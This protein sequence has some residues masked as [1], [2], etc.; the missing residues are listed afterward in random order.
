MPASEIGLLRLGRT[1]S[2]DDPELRAKLGEIQKG[3][4]QSTGYPFYFLQQRDDPR[5]IYLLGEWKSLDQHYNGL[6]GSPEFR[7]LARIQGAR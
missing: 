3:L 5:L 1:K 7:E 2:V 6:H 4:E